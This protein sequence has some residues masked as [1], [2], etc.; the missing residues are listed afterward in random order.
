MP[1]HNSPQQKKPA[2]LSL[3]F[4]VE[5]V[6][7]APSES[8]SMLASDSPLLSEARESLL[9]P[10]L[11]AFLFLGV[12]LALRLLRASLTLTLSFVSHSFSSDVSC[13]SDLGVV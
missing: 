2:Y 9:A 5:R 6:R 10:P 7:V 11:D 3:S 12:A 1:S 8:L 4:L 13:S